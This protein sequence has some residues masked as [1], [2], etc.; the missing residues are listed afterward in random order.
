LRAIRALARRQLTKT[1]LFD[2]V[3]EEIRKMA[4]GRFCWW[5]T[6]LTPPT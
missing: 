6:T 3:I 2:S 4:E 5:T 1:T